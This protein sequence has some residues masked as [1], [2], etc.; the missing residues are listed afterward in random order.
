MLHPQYPKVSILIINSAHETWPCEHKSKITHTN[1]SP[2]HWQMHHEHITTE[3]NIHTSDALIRD[4][5][6]VPIT[7]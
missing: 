3:P 4:F 6:D 2:N 1:F 7:D 5:A